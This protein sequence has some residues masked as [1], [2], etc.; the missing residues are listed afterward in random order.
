[1]KENSWKQF[2]VDVVFI[3]KKIKNNFKTIW[4]PVKKVYATIYRKFKVNISFNSKIKTM[5]LCCYLIYLQ[6]KRNVALND[7][8]I[9]FCIKITIIKFVIDI[10]ILYFTLYGLKDII[11]KL[12]GLLLYLKIIFRYLSLQKIYHFRHEFC[13]FFLPL[14]QF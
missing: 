8:N 1:M 7:R 14:V 3:L 6:L 9:I 5:Q 4:L 12:L 13:S 10:Q 11:Y 2:C